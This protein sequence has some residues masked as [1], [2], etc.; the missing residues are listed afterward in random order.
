MWS[1]IY[2]A[3][4][5]ALVIKWHY[6]LKCLTWTILLNLYWPIISTIMMWI[7]CNSVA[8]P[9]MLWET[10]TVTQSD[11]NDLGGKQTHL[12]LIWYNKMT[13]SGPC[14]LQLCQSDALSRLSGHL[15]TSSNSESQIQIS[16]LTKT[17]FFTLYFMK[18]A[19]SCCILHIYLYKCHMQH[20]LTFW[21]HLDTV[22]SGNNVE[23]DSTRQCNSLIKWLNDPRK[24]SPFSTQPLSIFL[25]CDTLLPLILRSM[26]RL[27]VCIQHRIRKPLSLIWDPS[28]MWSWT[29]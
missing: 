6:I 12:S 26:L 3:S 19:V 14:F 28:K 7:N 2:S 22:I 27:P 1:Q 17:P 24:L 13:E 20:L 4:W 5:V 10:S 9:P 18:L 11:A 15:G 16:H 29:E 25:I 23:R 21:C 8:E